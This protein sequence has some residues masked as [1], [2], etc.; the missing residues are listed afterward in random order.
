[1]QLSHVWKLHYNRKRFAIVIPFN[2]LPYF[3][4]PSFGIA[5]KYFDSSFCSEDYIFS[6]QTMQVIS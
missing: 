3:F 1:M 2:P 5:A 4:A 6:W